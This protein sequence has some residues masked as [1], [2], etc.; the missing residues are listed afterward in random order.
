M[1]ED[2]KLSAE[3]KHALNFSDQTKTFSL[4]LHYNGANNYLIVNNL[5]INKCKV[6]DS[7]INVFS[8][9]LGNVS[10]DFSVDDMKRLDYMDMSMISQLIMIVLILVMLEIFINI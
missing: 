8:L 7:E 3:K 4:S 6:K 5:E 1:L 9:C 10:K 2:T